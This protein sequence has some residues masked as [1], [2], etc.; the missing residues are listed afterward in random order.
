M[1]R[2]TKIRA[3]KIRAALRLCLALS[4]GAAHAQ[5]PL[6]TDQRA[7]TQAEAQAIADDWEARARAAYS[8]G[9]MGY[10]LECLD[11]AYALVPDPSYRANRVPILERLG[12]YQEAVEIL[13]WYLDTRPKAEKRALAEVMLARLAP[14]LTITTRPAGAQIY[15]DG[16]EIPVGRAPF[17]GAV[18]AG[19]HQVRLVLEDHHT[20]DI[21]VRVA[22]GKPAQLHKTLSRL[23]IPPGVD[24]AQLSS[25]PPP[26]ARGE[27]W[28]YALLGVALVGAGITGYFY[29]E[30]Q[31]AADA[32]DK[33]KTRAVWRSQNARAADM[34]EYY[35]V[36]MGLTLLA[37]V[38]SVFMLLSSPEEA[39]RGSAQVG[40]R[41]AGAWWRW[42]F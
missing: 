38:G 26:A 37:G 27:I 16:A 39:G 21:G 12:R 28:G 20:L 29:G 4:V 33:A 25:A 8:R 6:P 11:A 32:R 18:V 40:E 3:A 14:T 10:A 35:Q 15:L 41:G 2:G 24:P 31:S 22:P 36:S 5:G 23:E 19:S 9:D 30:G 1:S 7:R 17:S 13:R 34:Q 42:R